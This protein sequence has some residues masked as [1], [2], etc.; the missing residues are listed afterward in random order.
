MASKLIPYEGI[1]TPNKPCNLLS[2]HVK[3]IWLTYFVLHSLLVNEKFVLAAVF[4]PAGRSYENLEVSQ[5]EVIP[6]RE[7]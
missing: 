6:K 3:T 5:A 4:G 1:C 7:T 2:Y